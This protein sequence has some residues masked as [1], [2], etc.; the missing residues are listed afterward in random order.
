MKQSYKGGHDVSYRLRPLA[1]GSGTAVSSAYALVPRD[2][3][4]ER[5]PGRAGRC[6]WLSADG[7]E[8]SSPRSSVRSH[9]RPDGVLRTDRHAGSE[10]TRRNAEGWSRQRCT[11]LILLWELPYI[12]IKITILLRYCRGPATT[13]PGQLSE[14]HWRQKHHTDW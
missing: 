8:E 3:R 13:L 5:G 6:C 4:Y 1:T 9:N 11:C 10:H 2:C 14:R 12:S 7:G